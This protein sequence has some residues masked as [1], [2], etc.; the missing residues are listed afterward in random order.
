M[1]VTHN[2]KWQ[3]AQS[4][5]FQHRVQASLVAA[6]VNISSESPTTVPFHRERSDLARNILLAP[7][8]TNN[9]VQLFSNTVACDSSVINDAT[10]TGATAITAANMDAQQALVTDTHIDTAISAS[11]NSFARTPAN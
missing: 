1:A 9:Y 11:F 7:T 8:G 6:C 3:L 5:L 2:D 4:V 10:A